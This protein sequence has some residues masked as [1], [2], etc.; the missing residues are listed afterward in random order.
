MSSGVEHLSGS[1]VCTAR[2]VRRLSIGA[3]P[4]PHILS[5]RTYPISIYPKPALLGHH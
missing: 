2:K 1:C 3:V 5:L 4:T